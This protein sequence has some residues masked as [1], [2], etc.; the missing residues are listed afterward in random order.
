M[1]GTVSWWNEDRGYGCFISP[2]FE[3][4]IFAHRSDFA[5]PETDTSLIET[6]PVEFEIGEVGGRR[7]AVDVRRLVPELHQRYEGIVR[8]F[9]RKRG[10][11]WIERE[12]DNDIFVHWSD[13]VDQRKIKFLAPEEEV[14]FSIGIDEAERT[15][16]IFVTHDTRPALMQFAELND[17]LAHL[18]QLAHMAE[19]EL[20]SFKTED[21]D[22]FSILN[23]YV[24][25]TFRRSRF[26][27]RR[28]NRTTLP[29]KKL[30]SGRS[31][32][33]FNTGLVTP[34]EEPIYGYFT[35]NRTR[36]PK[37]PQWWLDG[38]CVRSDLRL[39]IFDNLPQRATFVDK[40][41]E[42]I[43]DWRIDLRVRKDHVS[44]RLSRLSP[45]VMSE[46]QRRGQ[47]VM[48]A[49][50]LAKDEA[51]RRIQ[52]DYKTA[53]PQFYRGEVQL[54]LPLC[55]VT[56]KRAD[57]ALVVE[58]HDEAYYGNT[59]LTLEQAYF[60]ARLIAKPDAEW[61]RPAG[62]E[63]EG[64]KQITL[65]IPETVIDEPYSNPQGELEDDEE[66]AEYMFEQPMD[67]GNTEADSETEDG[68]DED[69]KNRTN[70]QPPS[71]QP[72]HEPD[73]PD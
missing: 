19:P 63:K 4:E 21:P 69:E 52:R 3:G 8:S 12:N 66:P 20:W 47:S 55:I 64:S 50:D 14:E 18:K 42:L 2:E 57:V 73:R 49:I 35:T 11:G 34:F 43:Y 60:N 37:A 17:W 41:Q 15:R 56:R 51:V 5:D 27:A 24:I 71:P 72:V 6:E 53:V 32:A 7:Q 44:N 68:S 31:A 46:L 30:Q 1:T 59:I 67:S 26:E 23:H 33:C 25:N 61:L 13:I 16:A 38:F 22:D 48:E 40:P 54:L 39:S 62:F 45:N 36:D 9:D 10:T 65:D 29:V 28:L 70:N 58:R